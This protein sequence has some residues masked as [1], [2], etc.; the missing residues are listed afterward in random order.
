[1]RSRSGGPGRDRGATPEPSTWAMMMIGFAAFGY[2]GY[3]KR[4]KV[5][6]SSL[7]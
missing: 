4:A 7:A 2:M 3:R 1:L 6:L 5:T